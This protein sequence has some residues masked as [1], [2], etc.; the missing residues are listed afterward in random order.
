MDEENRITNKELGEAL[1]IGLLLIALCVMAIQL[2]NTQDRLTEL[3]RGTSEKASSQQEQIDSLSLYIE[4][5][6]EDMQSGFEDQQAQLD[7]Q[8][9]QIEKQ[10]QVSSATNKAFTRF[11]NQQSKVEEELREE[12]KKD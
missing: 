12:L 9:D 8:A 2:R 1:I 3:E 4:G 10:K 6:K 5:V 11:Q 7:S